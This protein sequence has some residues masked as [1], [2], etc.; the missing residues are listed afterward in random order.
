MAFISLW[1]V[2]VLVLVAIFAP[3]IAP[4]GPQETD[5]GHQL[6]PIGSPG[7]LLGTDTLG[8]D[9]LSRLVFGF[10]TALLVAFAAEVISVAVA[11]V[12]G[13]LAGYRGGRA[14]GILMAATDI[15]YAFPTYL[16]AVLLVT[17]FGRSFWSVMAAI[18][19]AGW[20]TQARLIRAQVMTLKRRDYVEAA[21]SMDAQGPTIAL[22]YI[23][24][25]ALGPL[26]VTTSFAVPAAITTEA[27]LSLLG[28]GI[29]DMPSWGAMINEG[30][31]YA[32][33]APHMIISPAIA[34]AVT[35][36]AFTW[37]GDGIRD[38][39]DITSEARR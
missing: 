19:V 29:S 38:A 15:M 30:V 37:I 34:F 21:R 39:F 10:R 12:V 25:N 36:L 20:V 22:R 27:G 1:V 23:L 3:F 11:L 7:H 32:S 33:S 14:D 5:Y 18:A 24:P 17:V 4:Y 9:I 31:R 13:L 26:L 28:L 16:F 8:R 35:L 6:A 2:A